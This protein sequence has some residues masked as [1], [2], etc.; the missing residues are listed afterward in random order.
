MPEKI[1]ETK[2]RC[3]WMDAGVVQFKLCD[4]DFDC[5]SCQFD[6]VMTESANRRSQG[7]CD[8]SAKRQIVRRLLAGEPAA[9][10]EETVPW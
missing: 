3:I 5:P 7:G 1:I 2:K 10:K 9:Q 8:E 6:W 4:S